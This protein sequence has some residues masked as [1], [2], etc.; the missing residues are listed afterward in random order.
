[1]DLNNTC[2]NVRPVGKAYWF[3]KLSEKAIS[4]TDVGET[5]ESL[6]VLIGAHVM[7]KL[8]TGRREVHS[9]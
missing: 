3:K 7:R 6:Q 1:M 5:P 8:L 2:E 4:L 9:S